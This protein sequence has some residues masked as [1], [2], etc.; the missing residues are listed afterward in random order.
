MG[1]FRAALD[2]MDKCNLNYFCPISFQ[3]YHK[4]NEIIEKRTAHFISVDSLEKL[5]K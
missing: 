1:I 5:D 3:E 2:Q 4:Q